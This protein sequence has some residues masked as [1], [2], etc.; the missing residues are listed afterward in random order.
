VTAHRKPIVTLVSAGQARVGM[1][2]IHRGLGPK[3][4]DCEYSQVCVGNLEP[5]RVYEIAKVRDK[6]LSCGQYET[7]M[8]VVEVFDAEIPAA[9]TAKQAIEG[10]VITFQMSDCGEEGC[11]DCELCFPTGLRAGD[12]CEVLSVTGSLPC[13]EGLLLKKVSLRRVPVS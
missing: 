2:F 6:T 4:E 10:A 9:I 12:R 1:I 8:Q 3:C 7:E 13:S 11:N 5:D